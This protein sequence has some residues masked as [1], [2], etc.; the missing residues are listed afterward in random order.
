MAGLSLW[1][2]L[3]IYDRVER[4]AVCTDGITRTLYVPTGA[5]QRELIDSLQVIGALVDTSTFIRWADHR[6]LRVPRPGRYVLA[7][8][9]SID[10]LVLKLRSG[11][12][13]PVRVTFSNIRDLNMLAER[14][15]RSLEPTAETFRTAMHDPA[16]YRAEGLGPATYICLYLPNTYEFWW[17]TSAKG[18]IDR[19]KREHDAFWNEERRVQAAAIG[20]DPAGVTT[21]ASIVQAETNRVEDASRIAGVYIN[22]LRIGMPLQADPTLKFALGI[23]SVNRVLDV[24]KSIDSPYNTYLHA[25]LPPGPISMPGTRYIDAVLHAE[26][27]NFLYFCA[28]DDLSGSSVFSRTY[29]QHLANARKYQRAL[30]HR[31]IYR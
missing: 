4:P 5:D 31:G 20:L 18:F 13:D 26:K 6:G 17:T 7:P 28:K 21:L 16:N 24:D 23:D 10:D 1:I 14:V 30:D 12:Q 9:L 19:M 27:H 11:S 3:D 2:A 25:G 22:R 29:Q 15:S 8:D